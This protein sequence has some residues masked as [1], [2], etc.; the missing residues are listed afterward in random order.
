MRKRYL[1]ITL[2]LYFVSA[3]AIWAATIG[4]LT[5]EKGSVKLRRQATERVIQEQGVQIPL[6]E[7]DELQ[8]GPGTMVKVHLSAK[9][10]EIILSS[11]TLFL[12]TSITESISEVKMTAGKARFLVKNLRRAKSGRKRFRLRT[13]NAIV[14]VKGTEFVTAVV[15]GKTD[16]LT[17]DGEVTMA[18]VSTP[19]VEVEVK[20]NQASQIQQDGQP[21][22]PVELPP[23]VIADIVKSDDPKAFNNVKFGAEVKVSSPTTQKK[24]AKK[25]T[26]TT[27]TS[28]ATAGA[29][30]TDGV[31]EP[32]DT[33]ETGLVED[34]IDEIISS[35]EDTVAEIIED[36]IEDIETGPTEREVTI[37]ITD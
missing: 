1:I 31:T 30:V 3:N 21:T 37:E 13:A 35:V 22:T 28:A 29:P 4:H 15:E 16:L 2:V 6:E 19:E 34:D 27:V 5:L 25:A 11:N 12:I 7:K 20:V 17:L 26:P 23:K 36:T 18:N 24:D 33:L 14:G 10:D 8:T 9:E 32:E